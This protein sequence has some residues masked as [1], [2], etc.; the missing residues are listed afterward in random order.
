MYNSIHCRIALGIS[1][2]TLLIFGLF[3]FPLSQRTNAQLQSDKLYYKMMASDNNISNRWI[4]PSSYVTISLGRNSLEADGGNNNNNAVVTWN[5]L[6]TGIGLQNKTPPPYFARNYALM[7]VAIYDA[8]LQSTSK[9]NNNEKPAEVAVVAGVAAEVLAY[10]FPENF[11]S[12]AALE[13]RQITHI[14][15]YN[16]SQI[17]DSRIIGHDVGKKVIAYSKMDASDALWDET[18]PSRSQGIGQVQIL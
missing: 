18:L 1:I 9:N 15:G 7:H 16:T 6:I 8:L 11:S 17:L 13:E 3:T 14:Q 10:L 5:Q 4:P 12:I 2:I